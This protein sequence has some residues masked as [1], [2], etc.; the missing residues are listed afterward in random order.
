M[1]TINYACGLHFDCVDGF[2]RGAT[3]FRA[4][5]GIIHAVGVIVGVNVGVYVGNAVGA[6]E[7][8]NVGVDVGVYEVTIRTL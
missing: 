5:G 6:N 2:G 4:F 7:G 3:H 8:V 1:S